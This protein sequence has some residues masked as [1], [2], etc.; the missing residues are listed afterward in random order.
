[1]VVVYAVL[2]AAVVAACVAS[3]VV[4]RHGEADVPAGDWRRTDEVF[5]DPTTGRRMRVW[6][7]PGDGCAATCPSRRPGRQVGTAPAPDRRAAVSA[8]ATV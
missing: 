1:M 6:V 7:D 8:P 4:R 2:A 5:L 3:L